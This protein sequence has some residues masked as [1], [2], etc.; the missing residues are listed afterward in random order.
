VP[1]FFL[2]SEE[3]S[4]TTPCLR[5]DEA[6]H[7]SQVHRCAP[8]QTIQLMDGAGRS[9]TAEILSA[10]KNEVCLTLLQSQQHPHPTQHLTLCAAVTKGDSYEW[11]LEKA[12]ELGAN[13]ILPVISERVIVRLS[14]ADAQRKQQKWQRLVQE[15]CKQCGQPW[16][17]QVLEPSSLLQTL[18]RVPA[19]T[20]RFCA[21]LTA[22][23]QHLSPQQLS[24][25]MDKALLIGPEGDFTSAEYDAIERSGWTPW[26][27]GSL[28][29]RSETAAIHALSLL[30]Y[31]TRPTRP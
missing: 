25:Q 24:Q 30:T 1:R 19:S 23:A 12:V 28:T 21:A 3:W 7:C 29:L 6:R 2:P 15:A 27:L 20:Q 11:I 14:P 13:T 17:P 8:G 16:M 10:T 18:A 9:G 22:T 5:E 26:T 4:E 31:H